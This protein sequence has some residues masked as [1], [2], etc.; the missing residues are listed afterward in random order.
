MLSIDSEIKSLVSQNATDTQIR[1]AA[2]RKGMKTLRMAG[3]DLAFLGVTSLG[4]V[5]SVTDIMG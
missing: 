4:E 1:A 5:L 2:I 3:L